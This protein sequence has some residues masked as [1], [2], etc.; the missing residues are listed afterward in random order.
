MQGIV[1]V[2]GQ[3]EEAARQKETV[4]ATV[5]VQEWLRYAMMRE[6]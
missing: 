4:D 5:V 1:I 2:V 3:E 6:G